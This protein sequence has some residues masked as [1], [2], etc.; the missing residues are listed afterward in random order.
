[1]VF[2]PKRSREHL[3]GIE[4]RIVLF[5]YAS[6]DSF[7]LRKLLRSLLEPPSDLGTADLALEA[8]LFRC[9]VTFIFQAWTGIQ[10]T[11]L[12]DFQHFPAFL[13]PLVVDGSPGLE[14]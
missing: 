7:D 14:D 3:V 9:G 8:F 11:H 2:R 1:M 6:S 4:C 10:D 13:L 5:L 12:K